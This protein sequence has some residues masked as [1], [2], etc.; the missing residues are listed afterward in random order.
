MESLVE[1][2]N[3]AEEDAPKRRYDRDYQPIID[4][5]EVQKEWN[6]AGITAW[7]NHQIQTHSG[8]GLRLS[9]FSG[10]TQSSA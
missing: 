2:Q 4:L 10:Q 3:V 8:N 6:E 1:G 7:K 5:A 9:G